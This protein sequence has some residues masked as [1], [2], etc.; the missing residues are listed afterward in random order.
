[1]FS[2]FLFY[3]WRKFAWT[4]GRVR[5]H[6]LRWARNPEGDFFLEDFFGDF[7][8]WKSDLLVVLAMGD[9]QWKKVA[10]CLQKDFFLRRLSHFQQWN[11][12]MEDNL[13]FIERG[14]SKWQKNKRTN[15]KKQ[16]TKQ[17]QNKKSTRNVC[18]NESYQI[19]VGSNVTNNYMSLQICFTGEST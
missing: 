8:K 19:K 2:Y 14:Q 16:K 3:H 9:M 6:P 1:M 12:T 5:E 15:S 17:Q 13:T 11:N 7:T 18:S 4:M 10:G